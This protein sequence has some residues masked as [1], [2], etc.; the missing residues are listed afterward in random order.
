MRCASPL[1]AG[2]PDEL[3]RLAHAPC[4][5][6]PVEPGDA[7]PEADVPGHVAVRE[8]RGVLEHEP[9][10]ASVWRDVGHVPLVEQHASG[11]GLLQSGD[12]PQDRRLARTARAEER[13]P[14]AGCD[15]ERD[16]LHD[17]TAL[18]RDAHPV[19]P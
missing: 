19:Q 2:E 9:D 17:P 11:R 14:L 4:A 13:E 15:V 6:L 5:L 16:V 7:R 10:P 12:D 1:G 18:D 3:E 8:E